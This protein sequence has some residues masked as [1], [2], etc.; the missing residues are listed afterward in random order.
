[1][2]LHT[3][4]IELNLILQKHF[5]SEQCHFNNLHT[6]SRLSL[7]QGREKT[8]SHYSEKTE[9]HYSE[10][11]ESHYVMSKKAQFKNT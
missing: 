11:T 5:I 1:M 3:L 7:F 8:E 9:S 6:L 4:L 2:T 10:K